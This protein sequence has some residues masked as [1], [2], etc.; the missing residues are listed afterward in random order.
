MDNSPA[1]TSGRLQAAPHVQQVAVSTP[2]GRWLDRRFSLFAIGPAVVAMAIIFGL[3]LVFSLFLSFHGWSIDQSL[4]AGRFVGF[5]NYHDLLTDP[6][7]VTSLVRTLVF[8][9]AVVAIELVLGLAIALLLNLELPGIG[10]FRTALIIPMMMTPIVAAL[11]WKLL[12]DPQNGIINYMIGRP[13]LWLGEP[14]LAMI[15]VSVVNI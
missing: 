8:T 7:F 12:L 15:S 4:F 10:L 11:C 3:P 6:E 1:E 14:T 2:F 13:I 5:A 9:L